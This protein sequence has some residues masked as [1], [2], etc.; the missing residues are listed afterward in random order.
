MSASPLEMTLR[1]VLKDDFKKAKAI[2][3]ISPYDWGPIQTSKRE[4]IDPKRNC[5]CMCVA[6]FGPNDY[7][8]VLIFWKGCSKKPRVVRAK[9]YPVRV[10]QRCGTKSKVY[11]S[12]LELSEDE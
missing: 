2:W 10:I 3:A 1:R 8:Y 4:I 6:K 9:G 5:T 11:R 7:A 12:K